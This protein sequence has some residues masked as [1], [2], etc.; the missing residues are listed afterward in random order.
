MKL[1]WRFLAPNVTIHLHT[2]YPIP[3]SELL[4]NTTIITPNIIPSLTSIIVTLLILQCSSVRDSDYH[5]LDGTDNEYP[6]PYPQKIL[7]YIN[8]TLDFEV[9]PRMPILYAIETPPPSA[10][11]P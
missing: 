7:K 9:S 4:H 8:I 1:Y 3:Q 11:N 5:S 6:T 10:Y 2:T